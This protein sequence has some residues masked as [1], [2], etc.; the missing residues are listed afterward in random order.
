M[1]GKTVS[2]C[3]LLITKRF[4]KPCPPKRIMWVSGSDTVDQS[5]EELINKH[6]PN[7]TNF[8]YGKPDCEKL[9]KMVREHDAWVFDDLAG[10]LGDDPNFTKFFTKTAHH[11]NCIVF[12]LT[13][14]PFEK[15][16]EAVTRTR[17]CAYQVYFHN[18][19]DI[20]WISVVGK[21]LL[22]NSRL[23]E[24]MFQSVMNSSY[25][26]LLCD[27]RATT[28]KED[29]Q[30]IGHPFTASDENPTCFLVPHK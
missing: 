11:K 20:R 4:F 21:Q 6:Y 10:E 13:Q 29:G 27:N 7:N 5:L 14:N 8:F 26:S 9:R 3:K 19:A 24:E 2:L 30:F 23:F 28:K 22:G 16:K 15:S 25:D 1:C 12:Y 18:N 17:N